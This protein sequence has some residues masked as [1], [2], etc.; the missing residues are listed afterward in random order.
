MVPTNVRQSAMHPNLFLRSFWR[1]SMRPQVFVAMSFAEAYRTRFEQVIAPAI[2]AVTHRGNQLAPLR[3]DLS[4]TGDSILTDIVDGIAHS[5]LVLADVSVAG[6]DSKTGQPY[7]N[8]NVM[9]EVGLALACR[10]PTEVLLLRDDRD[11]FLFDVSTVPHMQV[12]F[13][14]VEAARSCITDE[15]QARL[16]EVNTLQD[17]RL[18]IAVAT[19]TAHERT[20]LEVFAQFD[21]TQKFALPTNNLHL[22]SAMPRLLDKQLLRTVSLTKEGAA[23]FAWTEMGYALSRNITKLIPRELPPPSDSEGPATKSPDDGVA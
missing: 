7:R 10:Q 14:E 5:A 21:M 1:S 22:L 11:S 13:S 18:S 9:Y 8:G 17:A 4:K 20:L 2:A 23:R 12:D 15:I 3:V 19:M 16:R 6:R